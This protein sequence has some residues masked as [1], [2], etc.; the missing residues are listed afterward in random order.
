MPCSVWC[1][2]VMNCSSRK[3]I[4]E[5]IFV[6][7]LRAFCC[8]RSLLLQSARKLSIP[9]TCWLLHCRIPFP[10]FVLSLRTLCTLHTALVPFFLFLA[11]YYRTS[12]DLLLLLL[13]SPPPLFR[14]ADRIAS[15]FWLASQL[16]TWKCHC[17]VFILWGAHHNLFGGCRF[18]FQLTRQ[19]AKCCKL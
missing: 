13:L 9:G 6:P 11:L 2:T 10:C 1:G 14:W 19:L 4:A 18:N 5:V 3:F 16:S 12:S 8:S 15:L 17:T 7:F